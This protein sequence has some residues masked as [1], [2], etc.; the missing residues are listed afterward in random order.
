MCCVRFT[1][2]NG[3]RLKSTDLSMSV[4]FCFYYYVIDAA[5]V[6]E[7]CCVL[8]LTVVRCESVVGV[9]T[10]TRRA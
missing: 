10:A 7:K 6:V 1:I 5:E 4:L 8:N 9:K 2:L 3:I